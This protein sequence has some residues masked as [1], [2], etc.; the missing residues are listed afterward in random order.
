MYLYAM[1]MQTA[2]QYVKERRPAISPNLNFMGQLVEFENCK[3]KKDCV[4]LKLSDYTP[5]AEQEELT[6]RM[7]GRSSCSAG[8]SKENTP[9]ASRNTPEAAKLAGTDGPRFMLKLPASNKRKNKKKISPR[10][11]PRILTEDA[12][13]L[14]PNKQGCIDKKR[15]SEVKDEHPAINS[16]VKSLVGTAPTV[17][18]QLHK[19]S[20]EQAIKSFEKLQSSDSD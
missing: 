13:D 9:E 2:Y 16:V 10:T 12:V 11:S 20:V 19:G 3:D 7:K 14:T 4:T 1:P 6:E 5:S 15:E 17:L 18:S 8:S